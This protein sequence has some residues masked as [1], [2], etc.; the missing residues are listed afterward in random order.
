[1][2]H[3]AFK[4]FFMLPVELC[5]EDSG[6]AWGRVSLYT[7]VWR[8]HV[9]DRSFHSEILSRRHDEGEVSV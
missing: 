6:G 1:M 8:S 4:S 3:V 2:E 5:D 7:R 9:V